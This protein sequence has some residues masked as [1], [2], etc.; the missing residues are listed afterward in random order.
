MRK[1]CKTRT[2][3]KGK[4]KTNKGNEV[5]RGKSTLSVLNRNTNMK[6][7]AYAQQYCSTRSIR[8]CAGCH[9]ADIICLGLGKFRT[10]LYFRS[11]VEIGRIVY[12]LGSSAFGSSIKS[13]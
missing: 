10:R 8:R 7:V 12:T 3:N 5:S 4:S 2:S 1:P 6:D 13:Y 11:L 9:N